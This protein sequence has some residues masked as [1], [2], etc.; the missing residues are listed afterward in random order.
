MARTNRV[1][2]LSVATVTGTT[3]LCTA[4]PVAGAV[5]TDWRAGDAAASATRQAADHAIDVRTGSLTFSGPKYIGGRRAIYLTFDDG[6]ATNGTPQVLAALRA[7]KVKATFFEL[8]GLAS[9]AAGRALAA[10]VHAAGMPIGM[11]SWS[12]PNMARWS[13]AAVNSDMARTMAAIRSATREIPT[14]FRP[15]YGA[16]GSGVTAAANSRHLRVVLWDI[17]PR[18]WTSPGSA[19]VASRVISHLHP[20]AIVL[21]HDGAGHGRQAAAAIPSIVRA[22]RAKGYVFGTLCPMHSPRPH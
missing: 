1:L 10:R 19:A 2:A 13:T 12:H 20:G 9:T 18:D 14:C 5:A 11:H 4:V 8:G 22:A 7:N 16:Y 15:P 3:L 6:P 21:M 17:D